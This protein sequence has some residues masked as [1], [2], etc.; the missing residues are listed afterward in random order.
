MFRT[1]GGIRCSTQAKMNCLLVKG[2]L[3][4]RNT[5]DT[6][7]IAQAETFANVAILI[8]QNANNLWMCRSVVFS[9]AARVIFVLD[10]VRPCCGWTHCKKGK[11]AKKIK[12]FSVT[13]R[14]YRPFLQQYVL[15]LLVLPISLSEHK[16]L[17]VCRSQRKDKC[18]DFPQLVRG[19]CIFVFEY[20]RSSA[21]L[22]KKTW[23]EPSSLTIFFYLYIFTF[24]T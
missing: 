17:N 19:S 3:P 16:L 10:A 9:R 8:S 13:G 20:N 11:A 22:F 6:Y 18:F 23:P 1:D 15:M 24:K 21:V 12:M 5:I 7:C 2:L 14:E 4:K